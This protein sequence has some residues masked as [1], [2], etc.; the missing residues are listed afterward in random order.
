MSMS[1][2]GTLRP[3]HPPMEGPPHHLPARRPRKIKM[4]KCR[5]PWER[6]PK[7]VPPCTLPETNM[8]P[9]N[10]WLEY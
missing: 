6:Y 2:A 9:E 4:E 5:Y 10:G 1:M 8:A 7:F 3:S